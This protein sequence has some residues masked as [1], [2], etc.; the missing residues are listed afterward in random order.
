MCCCCWQKRP[1]SVGK[2][3]WKWWTNQSRKQVLTCGFISDG[4]LPS[5]VWQGNRGQ[6]TQ[7]HYTKTKSWKKKQRGIKMIDEKAI[8]NGLIKQSKTVGDWRLCGDALLPASV[9]GLWRLHL[10]WLLHWMK[11]VIRSSFWW[12]KKVLLVSMQVWRALDF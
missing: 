3:K 11:V 12:T 7:Q 6:N 10:S 5:L 2:Q 1:C 4:T 8:R 9:L